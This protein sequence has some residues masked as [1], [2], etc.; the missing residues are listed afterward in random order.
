MKHALFSC[1][2]NRLESEERLTGSVFGPNA[3]LAFPLQP[4]EKGSDLEG[5]QFEVA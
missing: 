4:F 3:L 2:G 1:E 5:A